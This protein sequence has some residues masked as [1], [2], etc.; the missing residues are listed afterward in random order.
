M[1][2]LDD[3]DVLHDRG[4]HKSIL[5]E[6]AGATDAQLTKSRTCLSRLTRRTDAS[7]KTLES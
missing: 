6:V 2:G 3:D 5:K 1:T 7:L 4:R